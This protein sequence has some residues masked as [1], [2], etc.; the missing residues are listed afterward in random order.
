MKLRLLTST[1]PKSL[2][3]EPVIARF[4]NAKFPIEGEL[5]RV[6]RQST[7]DLCCVSGENEEAEKMKV[8]EKLRKVMRARFQSE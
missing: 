3:L 4:E 8:Y 5:Y 2:M 6:L 1:S 7:K